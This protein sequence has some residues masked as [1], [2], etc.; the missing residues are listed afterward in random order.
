MSD[1]TGY[2][3]DAVGNYLKTS[4]A[5]V[6]RAALPDGVVEI[7]EEEWLAANVLVEEGAP[8]APSPVPE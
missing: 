3:M 2:F 8:V 6:F 5:S 4:N 1:D 7:T